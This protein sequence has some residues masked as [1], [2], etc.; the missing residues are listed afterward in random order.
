MEVAGKPALSE[1]ELRKLE[2]LKK[3]KAAKKAKK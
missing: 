2:E 1:A 3:L